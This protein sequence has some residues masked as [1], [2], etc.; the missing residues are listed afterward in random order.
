[1]TGPY[2]C[3]R[4]V[5]FHGSDGR[6]IGI[7]ISCAPDASISSRTIASILRI[8]RIPSGSVVNTPDISCRMNPA[9][10]SR[11]CDAASAS[12]GSSRRV[13]AYRWESLMDASG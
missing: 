5:F 1:M 11:R 12:A 7:R 13:G 3:H 8:V 9:R 10:T 2:A 6:R 4:P